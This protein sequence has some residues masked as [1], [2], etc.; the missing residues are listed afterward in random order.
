MSFTKIILSFLQTIFR[1]FSINDKIIR[2]IVVKVHSKREKIVTILKSRLIN[3]TL[4]A[5]IRIFNKYFFNL[6]ISKKEF[7]IIKIGYSRRF[8][9]YPFLNL[10]YY[11]QENFAI[12]KLFNQIVD[13]RKINL[14]N[15]S[16]EEIDIRYFFDYLHKK[17][18]SK[19]LKRLKMI[20]IPGGK[21]VISF[22]ERSLKKMNYS[23]DN[24]LVLLKNLDFNDINFDIQEKSYNITSYKKGDVF[25]RSYPEI[26]LNKD[27]LDILSNNECLIIVNDK[28]QINLK[29]LFG[30][31]V[32][33][34]INK[35]TK[36][37]DKNDLNSNSFPQDLVNKEKIIHFFLINLLE[38]NLKSLYPEIFRKIK[39]NF[40]KNLKLHFILPNKDVD[41]SGYLQFFNKG[42]IS[43]ICDNNG[44]NI[45]RIETV[46][47][48]SLSQ[49][50][51][52]ALIT[53]EKTTKK[54]K[55]CCLGHYSIR[56]SQLG[57]H[58]DGQIRAF[59]HLGYTKNIYLDLKVENYSSLRKKIL[60]HN[61]KI[62][63]V[64]LE[65]H[66]PFL[67][68][69][70]KDIKERNIIVIYWYVDIYEPKNLPK[71][72][73][74]IDFVF[75]TN[76]ELI[77]LYRERFRVQNI[78]YM[79]QACTP[80]FMHFRDLKEIYDIGF[81]GKCDVLSRPKDLR[82]QKFYYDHNSR[83]II[84]RKLAQKYNVKYV[85]GEYNNISEFYS[86]CKF[87]FGGTPHLA[88]FELY[89]SN[90]FF[91]AGGCGSVH[92][93]SY[94][95]GIEKLVENEKHVL[96][97][98]NE[99]EL[100]SLIDKYIDN[101]KERFKIKKNALDLFHM[102]HIYVNRIQNMLDIINGKTTEFYGFL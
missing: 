53:K 85:E 101:K 36:L 6:I 64:G 77:P 88:D 44:L 31:D 94:F 43:K 37:I 86:R 17:D 26:F 57:F 73:D 79:P 49:Y 52:T 38:F 82:G 12:E 100:Y 7:L 24:F 19:V 96:W 5:F 87:V 67:E 21:L 51:I 33:K 95:K 30:S 70:Q 25:K 80:P 55:I 14:S 58:W 39:S 27:Y 46:E 60:E 84:L 99:N 50:Y 97:F 72:G 13:I 90:R 29:N 78:F 65:E 32:L 8:E 23:I 4:S 56:Y 69:I 1:N 68:Y 92:L 71:L 47:K 98:K 45:E 61:P 20:L 54:D 9:Y 76:K 74:I 63:W 22:N 42:I 91:I 89:V 16:C 2:I 83:T 81:T 48:K 28:N 62:L 10:D 75:I 59:D 11:F 18:L 41:H 40:G 15:E 66:L 3:S 93:T 35:S 34:L 102:K